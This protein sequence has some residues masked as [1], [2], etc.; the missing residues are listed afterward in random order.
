[1]GSQ[2]TQNIGQGLNPGS[3][4]PQA[5]MA[6]NPMMP[7]PQPPM[8]PNQGQPFFGGTM[9]GNPFLDNAFNRAADSV[10]G[11]MRGATRFQG[12]SNSGVQQQYNRNLND[13]ATNV[14]GGAF[15]REANRR[16]DA[17][18]TISQ[19]QQA[20]RNADLNRMFTATQNLPGMLSS[21][22]QYG[23]GVGDVYRDYDQARINDAMRRFEAARAHPYQNLD[24]LGNV[25]RGAAGGGGTTT[26]TMPG[27][28]YYEPSPLSSIIGGGLLLSSL[29]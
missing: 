13:L 1:M 2:P 19:M 6:P 11:R 4:A 20:Q 27:Q 9:G 29:L 26:S 15:D 22:T 10:E 24:V 23:L 5:P 7:A 8:A 25:I 21:I 28:T 12:L 14:Y 17:G 18:K 3:P 16:L